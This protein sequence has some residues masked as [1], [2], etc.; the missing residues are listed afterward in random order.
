MRHET[1]PTHVSSVL[2]VANMLSDNVHKAKYA[3]LLQAHL[4]ICDR[5]LESLEEPEFFQIFRR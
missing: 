1:L 4:D 2:G 5:F 3:L